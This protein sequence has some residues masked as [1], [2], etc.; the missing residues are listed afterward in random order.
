VCGAA[1]GRIGRGVRADQIDPG[2]IVWCC[3]REALRERLRRSPGAIPWFAPLG[4]YD[5]EAENQL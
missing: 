5:F 1:S 2:F 3:A 4:V